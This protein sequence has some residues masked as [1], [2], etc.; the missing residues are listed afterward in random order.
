MVQKTYLARAIYKDG[1]KA[2]ALALVRD[3]INAIPDPVNIL[4]ER[5][6]IIEAK[7][8]LEDFE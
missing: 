5:F 6:E 4:E 1:Q 2:E 7:K 3:V 8:L